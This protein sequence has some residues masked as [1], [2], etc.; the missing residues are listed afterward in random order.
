MYNF[1][2]YLQDL[3]ES[4]GINFS[5]E[6]DKRIIFS[7][8]SKGV[9]LDD[10][11]EFDVYLGN[12]HAKVTVDNG[13]ESCIKLLKYCIE[14]RYKELFSLRE[15]SFID[16]L[17]E[18]QI[19]YEEI[20]TLFPNLPSPYTLILISVDG[21]R[22]EVLNI[23]KQLYNE[24]EVISV[25]YGDSVIIAG[26]FEEVL[27][28]AE[29]IKDSIASE[30]YCNCY[31][32]F[33]DNITSKEMVK[34]AY[35]DAKECMRIGKKFEVKNGI[36]NKSNLVFEKIAYN[37]NDK[38][39][40]ELLSKFKEKFNLFDAEMINTVEEFIECGLNISEAS[41]KLYI[42]RNTLIYRLDKI[43]KDTG[44]DIRDF[45]Q[46]TVF[47]IAFLTWKESK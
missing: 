33:S 10:I 47:I 3:C 6:C 16:I 43:H 20:Q 26:C 4:T 38:M 41:R 36:Y 22:H 42:H 40:S 29:S 7:T 28:H 39:K 8:G 23:I 2:S 19:S 32:S 13:D 11:L 17:E 34:S 27:E 21:S 9:D 45:K 15:Q 37:I 44:A 14:N 5:I 25:I 24:Q 12:K 30:L 18:K 1:N 46:A 35:D 31:I